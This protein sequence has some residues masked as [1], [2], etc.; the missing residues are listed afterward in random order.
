VNLLRLFFRVWSILRSHSR[1]ATQVPEWS[2]QN[3]TALAEFLKSEAGIRL[4]AHLRDRLAVASLGAVQRIGSDQAWHCGHAA[5]M[6]TL[7]AMLDSLSSV[8]G[9]TETRDDRPNDNLDWLNPKA[10]Q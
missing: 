7:V 6:H 2:E 3:A 5:G 8:T 1:L 4:G 9:D 10:P